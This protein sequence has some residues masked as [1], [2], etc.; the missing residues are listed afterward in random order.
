MKQKAIEQ[1]IKL[2]SEKRKEKGLHISAGLAW[3]IAT[4]P[5]LIMAG[6]SAHLYKFLPNYFPF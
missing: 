6:C 3:D 2:E 4:L 1:L 5:P